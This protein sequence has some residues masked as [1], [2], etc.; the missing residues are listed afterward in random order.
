MAAPLF[1]SVIAWFIT[2]CDQ[3]SNRSTATTQA[4]PPAISEVRL[5]FFPNLTHAQAVLG[6]T[7]GDFASAV[8]PAKF[9]PRQFNAGPALIEA[10]F[11]SQ[12]DVGYVG[13]GPVINA[14]ARSHG[15]GIRVIS[16]A[17]S[18][19]VV[20]V[21]RKDSGINSMADLGGKK[22]GT[23]QQGNTQDIAARHYL[24]AVLKQ[25]DT[26]NVLG[27]PNADQAGMMLRGNID[28][29]WSPEPWGSVL[30]STADAK[31]VGEEKDLWPNHEFS[32]TVIVTTPEFLRVH[33]DVVE[34]LLVVHRTWTA[35]L[36]AE[37]AKYVP[38]LEA[39]LASLTGKSL[40]PGVAADAIGR[41][42]FTDEPLPETFEA[43]A[44]WANE[45][46]FAKEKPDLAGLIDLAVLR[47]LQGK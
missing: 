34:K 42:K 3:S 39:A 35:R 7:S 2:G 10:L 36:N 24:T 6:V 20:I 14:W 26:N 43:N 12:I 21:A 37:P 46:G 5:G 28:A 47:K 11:A 17:V 32:L 31:I 8:G 27:I 25:P 19:G 9:T 22:I 40:K 29:A 4:S 16:G 44:T 45:L 41:V 1:L 33:A 23:P 13:P 18:N 15:D 30:V 38:Q